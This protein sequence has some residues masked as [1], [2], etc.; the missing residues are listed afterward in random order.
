MG[1]NQLNTFSTLT[2]PESVDRGGKTISS[3]S[4]DP[5]GIK[6]AMNPPLAV[7]IQE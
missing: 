6:T 2:S 7:P 4:L 3:S 5:V 1:K